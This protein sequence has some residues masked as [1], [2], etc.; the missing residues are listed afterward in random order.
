MFF[1]FGTLSLISNICT[2]MSVFSGLADIFQK[3]KLFFIPYLLISFTLTALYS[4]LHWILIIK[5]QFVQVDYM[6][7]EFWIPALIPVLPIYFYFSHRLKLFA[8]ASRKSNPLNFY[9]F[10][11]WISMAFSLGTTQ[12]FLEK[13]TGKL[14]ILDNVTQIYQLKKSKYYKLNRHYVHKKDVGI[15]KTTSVS[16]KHNEKFNMNIYVVMPLLP[17]VND[18]NNTFGMAWLAK[19]YQ[20]TI[21]NKVPQSSK[22]LSLEHFGQESAAEFEKEDFD[23]F[24]YLERPKPGK[25]LKAFEEALRYSPYYRFEN[26]VI[27]AG[28]RTPFNERLDASVDFMIGS[29]LVGCFIWLVMII[30]PNLRGRQS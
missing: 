23:D 14:S 12:N 2:L 16:G 22:K 28:I 15:Y 21:S 11:L 3:I 25:Q 5:F 29:F 13:A 19:N 8:F 4:F 17:S 1:I 24:V 27:L 6:Y 20:K 18:T 26:R 9:Y 7:I 30:I 10:I